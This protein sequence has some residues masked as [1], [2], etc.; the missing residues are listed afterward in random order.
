MPL[1]VLPL[2]YRHDIVADLYKKTIQDIAHLVKVTSVYLRQTVSCAQHVQNHQAFKAGSDW[3]IRHSN[4]P[5][6]KKGKEKN[7][8]ISNFPQQLAC[9]VPAAAVHLAPLVE[10]GRGRC[11]HCDTW[12]VIYMPLK[13]WGLCLANNWHTLHTQKSWQK[14]TGIKLWAE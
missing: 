3:K 10:G 12:Y 1:Y 6:Q 5:Y 13:C 7:C 11:K 2:A 8:S 14:F 9:P 4:F